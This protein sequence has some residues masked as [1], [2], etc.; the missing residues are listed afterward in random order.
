MA[1]VSRLPW[2]INDHWDWQL[3]AAC[4][5]MNSEVFFHPDGERDP[6]RSQRVAAAASICSGCPVREPCRDWARRVE[7]PYGVWGGE[8]EQERREHLARA[9]HH[10]RSA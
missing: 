5:G 7:E 8:S 9:R 10:D 3:H 2:A 1:D 4:R 6:R